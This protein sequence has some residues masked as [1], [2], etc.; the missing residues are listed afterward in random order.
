MNVKSAKSANSGV[1]HPTQRIT[2]AAAG[3]PVSAP[4]SEL[5][6]HAGYW[7][8]LVSN[9]VSH[10]FRRKVEAEGVTVSEWVVLRE[11]YRLGR[12]APGAL[13]GALG[14]TKGAVSKLIDR[15]QAKGLITSSVVEADRRHHAL[16][17]TREGRVLVPLLALL[18]D[19]NDEEFFGHLPKRQ[20]E[21]IVRAMQGIARIHGLQSIPVE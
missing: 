7:L 18:A 2:K 13:V 6:A 8:R 3:A 11:T 12:I 17:L 15:L 5:E 14:M 1:A 9:H 19:R 16:E 4:V 10:S 21:D 20:R